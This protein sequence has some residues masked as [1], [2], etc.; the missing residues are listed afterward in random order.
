MNFLKKLFVRSPDDYVRKGDTLFAA[1]SFYEA[2]TSYQDGLRCCQGTNGCDDLIARIA[3][4]ID[5]ANRSLAALNIDEAQHALNRGA[6]D[7]AVEHLELAI[8]LTHDTKI[9]EKAELML[10]DLVEKTNDPEELASPASCSSCSSCSPDSHGA[11]VDT[12]IDLDPLEHYDLLIHQLPE[13]M[14]VRYSC[15]GEEFAYMFIAASHDQ[16]TEALQLLEKWFD[17]SDRDIYCYE[18]GKILHRLGRVAEAETYWL[19][20]ISER[21]HNPLP[22]L[23]LALLYM[24]ENRLGDAA[25][26]ID[27]MIAADIFTGQALLM[28]GEVFELSGDLDGA[29]RQYGS[30]LDTPIV[31]SAAEKLHGLL[32]ACNRRP[33]AAHIF[34]QYLG[35]CQH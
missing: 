10:A 2:R 18:K 19:E 1:G 14:Y 6:V 23:G 8:T 4:K 9:R 25:R 26:Q 29:I 7:K 28:R 24:D 33:E 34:K 30:L 31:R 27:A 35:T 15:L 22:H 13:E 12:D 17:G 32:I 3:V 20:S 11:V 5:E 21:V 16:H